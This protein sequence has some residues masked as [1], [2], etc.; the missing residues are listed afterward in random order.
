MSTI[1]A[2]RATDGKPVTIVVDVSL[3]TEGHLALTVD[4]ADYLIDQNH[5]EAIWMVIKANWVELQAR[6]VSR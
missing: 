6:A 1:L 5:A 3:A 2:K 4:G